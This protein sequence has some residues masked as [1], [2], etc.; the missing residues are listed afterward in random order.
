MGSEDV[1]VFG[2]SEAGVIEK[3]GGRLIESA[4]GQ[5][6]SPL[7]P[8]QPILTTDHLAELPHDY[9]DRPNPG[10]GGLIERLDE[11]LDA[12]QLFAE[13]L[14]LNDLAV[15]NLGRQLVF[16][17]V[18]PVLGRCDPPVEVHDD[19][20]KALLKGH[21]AHGGPAYGGNRPNSIRPPSIFTELT[22]TTSTTSWRRS[23]SSSARTLRCTGSTASSPDLGRYD[24]M[25][26]AEAAGVPYA[27]Q[28]DEAGKQ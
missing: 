4:F 6:G 27:S 2:G 9:A 22:E 25:A 14:L 21:T 18:Q 7:R 16:Q 8:G 13:L 26:E 15:S 20:E 12:V 3:I 5:D 28:F 10:S 24:A 17:Q 19:V 1:G 11:E 23:R